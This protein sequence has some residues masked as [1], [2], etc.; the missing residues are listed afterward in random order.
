MALALGIAVVVTAPSAEA[1]DALRR[2]GFNL[3]FRLG[4]GV[5]VD[6]VVVDMLRRLLGDKSFADE[7]ASSW[8][9]RALLLL[10]PRE[11]VWGAGARGVPPH[12]RRLAA[13]GLQHSR[14]MVI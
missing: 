1:L 4:D 9:G 6:V 14:Q 7:C 5:V 13:R 3:L 10:A 8:Q 2:L 12:A 11:T